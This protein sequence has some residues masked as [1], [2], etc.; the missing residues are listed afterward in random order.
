MVTIALL[1]RLREALEYSVKKKCFRSEFIYCS[2]QISTYKSAHLT[3]TK[4][5]QYLLKF[6]FICLNVLVVP[7]TLQAET[8]RDVLCCCCCHSRF[9]YRPKFVPLVDSSAA[10][11]A[12]HMTHRSTSTGVRSSDPG[13][14]KTDLLCPVH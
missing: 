6:L 2:Y 13:S 9:S 7:V 4:Y 3:W 1:L 11:H 5:L 8:L 12:L 14:H 10:N